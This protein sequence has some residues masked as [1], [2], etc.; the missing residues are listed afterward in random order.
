[1]AHIDLLHMLGDAP[2]GPWAV[3]SLP[4]GD[5][6]GL[7]S[8]LVPRSLWLRLTRQ[9]PFSSELAIME[10]VGAAAITRVLAAGPV[11]SPV[12]VERGDLADAV[13]EEDDRWD[14]RLRT[15]ETCQRP[16]PPG[17]VAEALS[18]ALPPDSRGEIQLSV[19]CPRCQT[20][21]R[22]RLTPWGIP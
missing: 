19:L 1:M 5:G 16:V 17:E 22:H 3:F 8:V 2:E 4:H 21:T 18:N 10:R 13:V 12:L 14:E 9:D 6:T 20:Q 11:R 15:C 7:V